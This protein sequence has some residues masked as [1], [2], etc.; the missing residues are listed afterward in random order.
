MQIQ[1]NLKASDIS[2]TIQ[3]TSVLVSKLTTLARSQN[4]FSD[5]EEDFLRLTLTVKS[6][7]A[8]IKKK[9]ADLQ[10]WLKEN[11]LGGGRDA[12][13]SFGFGVFFILCNTNLFL[14]A[15]L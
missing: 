5:T 11:D 1:F 13:V 6:E 3:T 7:I 14:L 10:Q 2:K 9:L 12:K 15:A 4:M 8:N